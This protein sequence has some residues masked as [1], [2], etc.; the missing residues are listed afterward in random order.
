MHIVFI[1]GRWTPKS[2]IDL[3]K[4]ITLHRFHDRLTLALPP[5]I[6]HRSLENHYTK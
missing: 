4:T 1:F 5:P 6:E 2:G 3:Q